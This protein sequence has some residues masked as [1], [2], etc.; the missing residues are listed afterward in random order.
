MFQESNFF[1]FGYLLVCL[2]LSVILGR[3]IEGS[4][5]PNVIASQAK[6]WPQP[7]VILEG[8]NQVRGLAQPEASRPARSIPFATF[9]LQHYK[10]G[11][12]PSL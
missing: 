9:L 4:G 3:C 7:S 2:I 11:R 6:I 8:K 1:S 10:H 12:C 5:F